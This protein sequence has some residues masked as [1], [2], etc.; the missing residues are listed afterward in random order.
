MHPSGVP[1]VIHPGG[2]GDEPPVP[3]LS[4]PDPLPVVGGGF[5]PGAV[6]GGGGA[7]SFGH[8]PSGFFGLPF[9]H[10]AIGGGVQ[11]V[12]HPG[13]DG[14]GGVVQAVHP[15]GGAAVHET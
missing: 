8:V 12:L 2:Q 3:G 10:F 5:G 9:G 14:G 15:L 7:S 6:G 11:L 4:E 13:G 1:S